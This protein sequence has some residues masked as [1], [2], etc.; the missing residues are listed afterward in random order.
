V[1]RLQLKCLDPFLRH[2]VPVLTFPMKFM[3]Y[4][5]IYVYH[6]FSPCPSVNAP[7]EGSPKCVYFLFSVENLRKLQSSVG[8][9]MT[10]SAVL[11]ED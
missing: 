7:D 10:N 8:R 11:T 5:R 3:R 4:N 1:L 2:N 9:L 6:N